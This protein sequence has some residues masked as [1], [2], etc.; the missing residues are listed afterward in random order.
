M[1]LA[2]IVVTDLNNAIGRDN[3]LLCHLPA[4]LRFFKSTTMGSPVIM[5]RKTY[6]SIGRP[7]KGRRN[8]IITRSSDYRVEGADIY[9]NIDAAIASCTEEKVFIIGGA[10][11]FRQTL[12]VT[13]EIF[14]TLIEHRFEAD[15]FFPPFAEDFE[16]VSRECFS[17][18][19]KNPYD[20][21]FEKWRR[22]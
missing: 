4:D 8:I 13:T 19:E 14:R 2:A 1:I 16:I 6:E 12:P 9:H 7:L 17:C 10:E 15:T 21:C 22:K 20:Y 18:D 3:K 11:I 5:G